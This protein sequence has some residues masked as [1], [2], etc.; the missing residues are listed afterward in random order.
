MQE[1]HIEIKLFSQYLSAQTYKVVYTGVS[2]RGGYK[3]F[4]KLQKGLNVNLSE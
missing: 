3:Q 4:D 1:S 2:Q